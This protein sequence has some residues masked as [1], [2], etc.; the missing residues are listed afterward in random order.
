M[1]AIIRVFSTILILMRVMVYGMMIR[2]FTMNLGR[3]SASPI[4]VTKLM[5]YE[6]SVMALNELCRDRGAKYLN[7]KLDAGA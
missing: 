7:T 5:V 1:L 4:S 3:A 2:L 6:K